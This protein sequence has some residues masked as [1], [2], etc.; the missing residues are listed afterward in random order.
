MFRRLAL[1]A[2]LSLAAPLA[3]KNG[4]GQRMAPSAPGARLAPAVVIDTGARKVAFRVEVARTPDEQARGLMYREHLDAD[5][6]MLFVSAAPR[7]QVFWM[8]NTLIPLDMIFISADRRIVGIVADA[9]P[10]TITSRKVDAPSQFVLEI[11]GGLSAQLGIRPGQL[12]E[13]R[14][15]ETAPEM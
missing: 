11:G 4:D 9:E 12:L 6:G 10:R 8:K 14:N 15:I 2:A 13:L 7:L 3:C 1:V 5:A